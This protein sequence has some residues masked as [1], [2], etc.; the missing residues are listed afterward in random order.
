MRTQWRAVLGFVLSIAL[1][2]WTLRD[3]SFGAVWAVLRASDPWLFA[4]STFCG[5]IIFALRA[6]RWAPILHDV[7]P[8]VPYGALWRSTAVGMM[9][10]N[11]VPARAGE[12]MRAFALTRERRE[13]PFAAAFASLVV[14]RLFDSVVLL[15]LLASALLAPGFPTDVTLGGRPVRDLAWSLGALSGTAA[16]VVGLLAFAPNLVVRL[17]EVV[18]GRVSPRLE[19]KGSALLRTFASGMGVLRSPRRFALVFA[20]TLAHWLC[21]AL[22]FW[23]AFRAVGIVL[24]FSAANFL[25]GVIAM[26]VAI[27]SSPGFFGVFE[28]VAK[29]GLGVYGV[30]PDR[31]LAWAF[32]YHLLTYVPITLLG[33]YHFA[34]M[35]LSLAQ[36]Q[37]AERDAEGAA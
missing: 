10:N 27:P 31:A 21:N 11:V 4:A 13:V 8:D 15:L 1:L 16:V 36:A 25:Q 12:L 37:R 35:G 30:A 26:G 33:A 2:A 23:L 14:D 28:S 22:A 5:T 18:V 9:V 20:W 34:A 32:G 7:A 3:V 24:P 6:A 17:F 29:A 19:A